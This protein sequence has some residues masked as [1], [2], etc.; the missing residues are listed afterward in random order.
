MMARVRAMVGGVELY[1]LSLLG[2]LL[3][4]G[5]LAV[6]VPGFSLGMVF[7]LPVPLL[8]ARRLSGAVRRRTRHWTGLGIREP[9]RPAPAPPVPQADGWYVR[10]RRLYRRAW[11]PR[12]LDRIDWVLGDNA[13]WR[14][15]GWMLLAPV[16][17]GLVGLLPVLLVAGGP[18]LLLAG[19]PRWVA[20]AGGAVSAAAGLALAPAALRAS[21]RFHRR[22]LGGPLFRSDVHDIH[23]DHR[24]RAW[25]A[26]TFTPVLRL[27]VLFLTS[28][29]AVPVFVATVLGLLL[30]YGLGLIFLVPWVLEDLR[31][32]A[33]W[34]RSLARWSGVSIAR[35]YQPMPPL[36]PRLEDGLYQ[37]GK[38]LYKT[39][40]WARWAQRWRWLQTDPATWREVLWRGADPVVGGVLAGVPVL[41]VG[42]GIWGLVLPRITQTFLG[43]PGSDWYGHLAGQA[44]PAIPVGLL[45]TVLGVLLSP[46]ALRLHGR[47]SRVLLG[48]TAE[49][50]LTHRVEQLA[51]S[52][53][54]ASAAAARELRRIERDLHDGTQARLVALGMS[55]GAIERLLDTDPIAAKELLVATRESAALALRELREVVRGI[56]PPVLAERGLGDAVRALALDSPLPATVTVR[57]A[58]RLPDPIEAA[59]YFA[60]AEALGNA[61]KHARASKVEIVLTQAGEMLRIVVR[62]DGRGGADPDRGSGLRG[63][64]RRLGI[65]DGTVTI[66]SPP[67]GPTELT[68]EIPCAS[69]SP[70]TSTF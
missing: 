66:S 54:D 64:A 50:V 26:T 43:A 45:L 57:L 27:A 22:L 69:S 9:Y 36:V 67:G 25:A 53:A 20:I 18:L 42:Y 39:Q 6:F 52:R 60:V 10:D 70:R 46:V 38:D 33:D 2:L 40:R 23:P 4:A 7:L 63:L 11:G 19:L 24:V 51:S 65:F 12:L 16:S 31:W 56:H 68:M 28:A 30:G 37:I 35:P 21:A 3:F 8:V 61:A 29:L 17:G 5:I 14:D 1:A 13:T 34:R 49:T 55:L 48:P 62:D 47:W 44:W 58:G 41:M 15:L 59:A 32:L